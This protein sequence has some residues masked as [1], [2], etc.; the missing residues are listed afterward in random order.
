MRKNI[1]LTGMSGAGKSYIGKAVADKLG[2]DYFDSDEEFEKEENAN[3]SDFF[4]KNREEYFRKRESDIIKR[5]SRKSSSVISTGGGSVLKEE[6]VSNLKSN[7][8]VFY[9]ERDIDVILDTVDK[10]GRPLLKG[11]KNAIRKLFRQRK[12]IYENSADYKISN[13]DSP[14]ETIEKICKIY[15]EYKSVVK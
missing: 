6:N 10:E 2:L 14:E 5:L 3:I 8:I 15:E 13:N 1:V 11:G 7:G 12:S 4:I 9:L